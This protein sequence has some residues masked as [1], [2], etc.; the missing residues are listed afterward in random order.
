M[1]PTAGTPTVTWVRTIAEVRPRRL[2]PFR[3]VEGEWVTN[4]RTMFVERLAPG[5]R[6]TPSVSLL[7]RH[8]FAKLLTDAEVAR[9]RAWARKRG[10]VVRTTRKTFV[11]ERYPNLAGD[12]DCSTDLLRRL[13]R[14][15]ERLSK[16]EGRKVVVFVR[17]GL[18][19]LA[20]QTVLWNR[21]GPPRAARPNPNA[22]HV[23]G[24]AADCGIDG[25]DI[26]DYPGARDAMRAEGL[27]LR[28][29]G[30]DWHVEV[31]DTWRA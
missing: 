14:V 23:R 16:R 4:S 2:T 20:E 31:G 9:V 1:T 7:P 19:T 29:V 11:I 13:Q 18:R 12:L 26:G 21:Y 3:R 25:R 5:S 27:C 22:P 24:I 15:A 30:E 10:W 6:K 28:V 17:S 8:G